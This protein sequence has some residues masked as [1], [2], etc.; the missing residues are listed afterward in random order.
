MQKLYVFLGCVMLLCVAVPRTARTRQQDSGP[1]LSEQGKR[2]SAALERKYPRGIVLGEII[3]KRKSSAAHTFSERQV[4]P[5]GLDSGARQISGDTFI[6]RLPANT[7]RTLSE[8]DKRG[9][10][11]AAVKSLQAMPDVE[12]VQPNYIYR[13]AATTPADPLYPQQWHYFDNGS[14]AG[15]SLGGIGLPD[16]WAANTGK[17]SVVVA[18]LDTGILPD[19]PGIAGSPNL[20]AGYDMISDSFMANDGDGRDPDPT[21]PGDGVQAGECGGGLPLNAEEDSWHGTHVAGTIGVGKSNSGIGVTGVNWNVKILPVRVLG[22]CGGTTADIADAIRWAAGI[23]VPG[24]PDNTNKAAVINMSLAGDGACSDDQVTQS[25]INDAVRAGVSVVVAAGNSAQDASRETPAGCNNVISVAAS[26]PRGYLVTRYSNFGSTVK[27][28][29]PGGDTQSDQKNGVLSMVK[30][31]Y[32]YYNGTSMAAPH[33][34]GVA[35]LLKACDPSLSPAQV[36]AKLQTSALHRTP[37]QCPLACGAGLLNAAAA[38]CGKPAAGPPSG[39]LSIT[40]SPANLNLSRSGMMDVTA[41]V[42]QGGLPANGVTVSFTSGDPSVATIDSPSVVTDSGFAKSRVQA[43]HKGDT[44]VSASVP[45]ATAKAHVRVPALSVI[46]TLILLVIIFVA[47]T[48]VS[49]RR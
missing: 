21:D 38:S 6:Y 20:L 18:V 13:I 7:M 41:T 44:E 3:V 17:S 42:E 29:A 27:I 32:A 1:I 12:Y 10:T 48:A 15:Q 37:T 36:L 19:H 43:S 47:A 23:S 14:A 9:R 24:V 30:G 40:L 26:D 5:L 31:G 16:V 33:V 28:M 11:L 35:A 2:V 22:K 45:G 46:G 25:A 4:S 8:D 39:P 34:A 49:A